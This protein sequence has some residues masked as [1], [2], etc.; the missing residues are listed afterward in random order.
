MMYPSRGVD[1]VFARIFVGEADVARNKKQLEKLGI[2]H[3][4][5]CSSNA[6]RT[7][8]DFYGKG[9]QYMGIPAGTGVVNFDL[10]D[11]VCVCVCVCVCVYYGKRKKKMQK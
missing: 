10:F 8:P 1:E 6:V 2:T 7:G 11:V 5:N 9:F 3:V 4:V